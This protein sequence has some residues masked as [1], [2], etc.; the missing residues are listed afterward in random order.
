MDSIADAIVYAVAYIGCRE[1][2]EDSL[3]ED[4]PAMA[5]IMAKNIAPPARKANRCG[6]NQRLANAIE[7]I[8][9]TADPVPMTGR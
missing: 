6:G 7:P 3:D 8:S 9:P 4:D 1:E 5:H 2:C